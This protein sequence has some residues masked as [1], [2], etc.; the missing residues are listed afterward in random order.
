MKLL[1]FPSL[2]LPLYLHIAVATA[3][4]EYSYT[5]DPNAAMY[6]VLTASL[7]DGGTQVCSGDESTT[8]PFNTPYIFTCIDNDHKLDIRVSYGDAQAS[9][10]TYYT[11]EFNYTVGAD[12][13][14]WKDVSTVQTMSKFSGS[15][16]Q[17]C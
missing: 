16:T 3:C 14:Q 11:A 13:Y 1:E 12:S 5:W 4:V 2:L 6:P 9:P 15:G 7:K 10:P 8:D 17:L